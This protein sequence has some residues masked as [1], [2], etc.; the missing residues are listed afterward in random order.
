MSEVFRDV[1][2]GE[3]WDICSKMMDKLLHFEPPTSK[4]GY[5]VGPLWVR[6][7]HSALGNTA[8]VHLLNDLEVLNGPQ[9]K[10]ELCSKSK[11]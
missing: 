7:Q 8:L 3:C 1:T 6:K 9:S 10:K 5:K 2:S 11:L 4:K